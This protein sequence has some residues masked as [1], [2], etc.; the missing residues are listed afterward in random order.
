MPITAVLDVIVL[1]DGAN[2]RRDYSL[3]LRVRRSE[4]PLAM[5]HSPAYSITDGWE[6]L[7]LDG[8][9]TET[10]TSTSYWP[11]VEEAIA[12]AEA[13]VNDHRINGKTFSERS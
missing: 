6:Y 3:G 12:A 1:P 8:S 2:L 9:W 5:D 10:R 7:N 4:A 13:V 11:T